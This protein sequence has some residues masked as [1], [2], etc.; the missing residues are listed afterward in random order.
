MLPT[1]VSNRPLRYFTESAKALAKKTGV[2]LI[3]RDR[4]AQMIEQLNGHPKDEA[5]LSS[6]F[7]IRPSTPRIP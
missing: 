5:R 7:M 3:D 2:V 6:L 1:H 4:L